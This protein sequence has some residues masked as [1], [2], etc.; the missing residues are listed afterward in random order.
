MIGTVMMLGIV[1]ILG[2]VV[3]SMAFGLDGRLDEPQ[4]EDPFQ[5]EYEADGEGNTDN[6][7][8]VKLTHQMGEPTDS[9]NIVI[10]DESGNTLKWGDIW[11]GGPE[12]KAGESVHLDGFGSDSV[13]DPICEKGDTYWVV[14]KDDDG[15]NVVVNEWSAPEGPD[16][17]HRDEDGDVI[18]SNHNGIPDWC[19]GEP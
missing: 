14:L 17:P 11:L 1:V 15:D 19:P 5:K 12:V 13:L 10:R 18:D 4:L 2:A 7:P 6:R 8:F 3:A 9:S 16:V